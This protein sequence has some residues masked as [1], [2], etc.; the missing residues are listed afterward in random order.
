LELERKQAKTAAASNVRNM[1]HLKQQRRCG[2]KQPQQTPREL[3]KRSFEF[4]I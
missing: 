1:Q 4:E 3:Q 2:A